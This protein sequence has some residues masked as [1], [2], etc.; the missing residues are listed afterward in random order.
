ME[1]L[2]R[3]RR[4]SCRG[5]RA[6]VSGCKQCMSANCSVGIRNKQSSHSW[7]SALSA[8]RVY[9]NPAVSLCPLLCMMF[10][11]K[12]RVIGRPPGGLQ[13]MCARQCVDSRQ[14]CLARH[15]SLHSL[16]CLATRA[17][18][19]PV[20]CSCSGCQHVRRVLF[21]PFLAQTYGSALRAWPRANGRHR[22]WGKL[23]WCPRWRPSRTLVGRSAVDCHRPSGLPGNGVRILRTN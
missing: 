14:H 2:A 11:R 8:N 18:M 21:A 7:D 20:R 23:I 3:R 17:I 5:R 9:E 13:R 12:Q 22:C 1:P 6:V 10:P 16:Q 15:D 19:M 4:R